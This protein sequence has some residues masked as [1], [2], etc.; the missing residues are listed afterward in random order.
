[1]VGGD[2]KNG[3]LATKTSQTARDV[4]PHQGLSLQA[5][6]LINCR[7][8]WSGQ[9]AFVGFAGIR[10][11]GRINIRDTIDV[12]LRGSTHAALMPPN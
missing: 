7:A 6:M 8:V 4:N 3:K 2:A 11:P 5:R 10:W 12:T 1:M 9:R